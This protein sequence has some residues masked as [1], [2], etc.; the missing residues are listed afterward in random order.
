MSDRIVETVDD[1]FFKLSFGDDCG[2]DRYFELSHF[3]DGVQLEMTVPEC[4]VRRVRHNANGKTYLKVIIS[5]HTE[6]LIA[7]LTKL[8]K[9]G[10]KLSDV[11]VGR[12]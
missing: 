5:D 8:I 10:E 6:D 9:A 4:R 2:T 11:A 7:R 12:E 3:C 1:H